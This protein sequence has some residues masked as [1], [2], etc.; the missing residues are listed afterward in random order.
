MYAVVG[1]RQRDWQNQCT[2]SLRQQLR[3]LIQ[4]AAAGTL[5]TPQQQCLTALSKQSADFDDDWTWIPDQHNRGLKVIPGDEGCI[6]EISL[7]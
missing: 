3:S 4:T 5:T 2:A 6:V 7:L 1:K